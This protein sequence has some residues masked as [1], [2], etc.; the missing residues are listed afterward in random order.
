M[1]I[2]PAPGPTHASVARSWDETPAFRGVV[3]DAPELAAAHERPGQYVKLESDAGKGFFALASAPG[4]PLE[5][6]V[7]KGA[8]FADALAALPVGARIA[9]SAP[10]G[11]GYPVRDHSGQDVLLF[12]A[13][14]GIAPIRSVV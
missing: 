1:S 10:A 7:K 2:A 5:L 8:P 13:G 4:A 14:S 6:L 12:A 3:L 11:Q 9:A